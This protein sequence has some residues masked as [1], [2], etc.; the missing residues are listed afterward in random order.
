MKKI[1]I[2]TIALSLATLT[3]AERRSI[4]E[5]SENWLQATAT[6]EETTGSL[7]AEGGNRTGG[8]EAQGDVNVPVGEG[9]LSILLLSGLYG[10][11]RKK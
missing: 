6:S 11:C 4:K 1:L 8:E 9:L 2:I 7:R 3:F 5:R 10:Y